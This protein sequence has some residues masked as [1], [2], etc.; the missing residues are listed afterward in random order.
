MTISSIVINLKK[1]NFKDEVIKKVK[2]FKECEIV[3]SQDNK[4]VVIVSTK[5]T[6]EQISIFK[7]IQNING[8]DDVAMIYSYDE[9]DKDIKNLKN[10]PSVSKILDDDVDTKDVVYKGSIHYKVK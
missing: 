1:E 7:Q 10:A 5:N 9:L 6:D 8:V 3:T 2:T 4:I